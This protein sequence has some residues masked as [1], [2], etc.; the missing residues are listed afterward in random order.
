MANSEC[1]NLP[2]SFDCICDTGFKKVDEKCQ[3]KDNSLC[4]TSNLN[5]DYSMKLTCSQG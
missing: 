2:G 3:G 4:K 5:I 1:E